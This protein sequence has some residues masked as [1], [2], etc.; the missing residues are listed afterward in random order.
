MGPLCFFLTAFWAESLWMGQEY[1]L[2][3]GLQ[4]QSTLIFGRSCLSLADWW[5]QCFWAL[6][7]PVSQTLG[8]EMEV[9][10]PVHPAWPCET[11]AAGWQ[12]HS[13]APQRLLSSSHHTHIHR[14]GKTQKLLKCSN[15]S[16]QYCTFLRTR[17]RQADLQ[18]FPQVTF[19]HTYVKIVVSEG[20]I[21]KISL[22]C[23]KSTY[24][25]K[26]KITE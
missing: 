5:G 6:C 12:P 26:L 1:C 22:C 13:P 18:P 2:W 8:R 3:S 20:E 23:V 15:I 9:R 25:I 4:K 10:S 14:P 24:K 16:H 21:T 11:S 7:L 17:D 19:L